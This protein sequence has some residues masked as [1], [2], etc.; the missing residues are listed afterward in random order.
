MNYKTVL[1]VRTRLTHLSRELS[2]NIYNMPSSFIVQ[3]SYINSVYHLN[4]SNNTIVYHGYLVTDI[5]D[6][7]FCTTRIHVY[8]N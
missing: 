1:Y 4:T 5:I 3:S 8:I 6:Q 7:T 2:F